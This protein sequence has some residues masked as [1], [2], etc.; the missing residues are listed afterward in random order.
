[1]TIG[2]LSLPRI[3]DDPVAL[4]FSGTTEDIDVRLKLVVSSAWAATSCPVTQGALTADPAALDQAAR[5][6]SMHSPTRASS[7]LGVPPPRCRPRRSLSGRI[8]LTR[9]VKSRSRQD[10][11]SPLS[12]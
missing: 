10:A 3:G 12:A 6:R 4:A 8:G 5:P 1:V 7:A 9:A 11:I 2:Q